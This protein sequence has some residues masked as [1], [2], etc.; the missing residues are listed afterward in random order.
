MVT[1][2]ELLISLTLI[3]LICKDEMMARV[4]IAHRAEM[5]AK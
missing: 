5:R 1:Q 2:G 4:S 3:F